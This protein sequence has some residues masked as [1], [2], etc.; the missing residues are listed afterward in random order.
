MVAYAGVALP[1]V[2]KLLHIIFKQKNCPKD[3]LIGYLMDKFSQLTS[4]FPHHSR[5]VLIWEEKLSS[6][7]TCL[8]AGRKVLKLRVFLIH[9]SIYKTLYKPEHNN[10]AED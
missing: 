1:A 5:F 2:G 3:F 6:T 7:P 4:I 9:L 10:C 8:F